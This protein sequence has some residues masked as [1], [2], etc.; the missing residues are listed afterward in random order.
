MSGEDRL[1]MTDDAVGVLEDRDEIHDI[2][3]RYS[4][5]VDQREME[6]VRA[7][8]A[9]DLKTVG[10][11]PGEGFDR[12][13]LIR[14][15]SGVGHFRETMHMMGNQLI[16]VSGD[17]AS[18]DTFAQL[19]HRLDGDPAKL[20]VSSRYVEKLTR[21]D[22]EWAITQRGGEPAWAPNG[23]DARHSD[24]AAV[25]WLLDRAAI[26]DA[27][28]RDTV[29]A[30]SAGIGSAATGRV[31]NFLGTRLVTVDGDDAWADSYVLVTPIADGEDRARPADLLTPVRWSDHLVRDGGRWRL[32]ARD[33][34]GPGHF[35]ALPVPPPTDDAR[36]GALL[37]RA[38]VIDAVTAT[39]YAIDHQD[40]ALLRACVA[41]DVTVGEAEIGV[42]SGVDALVDVLRATM[43]AMDGT[44]L[45]M[46]NH[47]V[48]VTG[49]RAS[50]QS[51]V[52]IIERPA[53][54]DEPLSWTEGARR[55]VD[56]LQRDGSGWRVVERRVETNMMPDD[57]V[58][59]RPEGEQSIEA[60]TRRAEARARE[61][62]D[63]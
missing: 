63:E 24:D 48:D 17:T 39:S 43:W 18:M 16:E 21:R 22:G 36:V 56:R 37:D 9:P 8:F 44:W 32:D 58:M 35:H 46:N 57:K 52:F 15:I 29:A 28:V 5:G 13:A 19:T 12:D 31:R 14:F 26:R 27:I 33:V 23:V 1:L 20:L 30:D 49:E 54:A 2:M 11:G 60:M 42:V 34:D 4:H 3:M 62:D 47:M 51:Y 7:C 40:E 55:F 41:P 45:F 59:Q 53:G 6:V 38:M 25:R 10:W 61:Q 50:V